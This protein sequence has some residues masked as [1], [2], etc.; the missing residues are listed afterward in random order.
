MAT[1]FAK[2]AV[3]CHVRGHLTDEL[4]ARATGAA[5]ST[6]RGWLALRT[7][8]SRERAERLNEL[9]EIVDRLSRVIAAEYVPVWLTKPVAAL[10][11]EKPIDLVAQGRYIEVLRLISALDEPG[12]A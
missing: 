7:A 9:A 10:G 1:A 4:I 3:R 8:P 11:D 5:P 12:A 6:V 2:E